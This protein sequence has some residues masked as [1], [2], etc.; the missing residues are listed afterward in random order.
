MNNLLLYPLMSDFPFLN[1]QME[2][3]A[4]SHVHLTS[5]LLYP[6]QPTLEWECGME[7]AVALLEDHLPDMDSCVFILILDYVVLQVLL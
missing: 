6:P 4:K 7:T 1:R 3:L 2:T 5:S